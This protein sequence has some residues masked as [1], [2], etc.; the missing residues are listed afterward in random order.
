M[1]QQF[2]PIAKG[3][4][5]GEAVTIGQRRGLNLGGTDEPRYVTDVDIASGRVTVGRRDG[6]A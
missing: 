2:G 5:A 6:A 3:G 1:M 4:E